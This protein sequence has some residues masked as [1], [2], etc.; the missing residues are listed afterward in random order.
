MAAIVARPWRCLRSR[1]CARQASQSPWPTFVV[2]PNCF[3]RTRCLATPRVPDFL[4]EGRPGRPCWIITSG[5]RVKGRRCAL[6][7]SLALAKI[8]PRACSLRWALPPMTRCALPRAPR[9]SGHELSSPSRQCHT[10]AQIDGPGR[11]RCGAPGRRG[12]IA[13]SCRRDL[14]RVEE[15]IPRPCRGGAACAVTMPRSRPWYAGWPLRPW[16]PART[17][18][19]RMIWEARSPCLITDFRARAVTPVLSLAQPRDNAPSLTAAARGAAEA[20]VAH[21]SSLR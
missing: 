7:L 12:I 15:G 1:G 14:A 21:R 20:E 11:G 9:T 10:V 6:G 5:G 2:P 18:S 13:I 8:S 4:F 19:R 16:K 17:R 3:P